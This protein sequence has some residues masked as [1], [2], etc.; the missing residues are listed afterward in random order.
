M[1]RRLNSIPCIILQIPAPCKHAHVWSCEFDMVPFGDASQNSP[2]MLAGLPNFFPS[3]S[4]FHDICFSFFFHGG[5]CFTFIIQSFWYGKTGCSRQRI[6][7]CSQKNSRET[8]HNG[9]HAFNNHI[10]QAIVPHVPPA[11]LWCDW[12]SL[13]S[14]ACIQTKTQEQKSKIC[15][16]K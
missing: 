16:E 4:S 6:S 15:R 10:R 9:S 13:I 2:L 12:L 11:T 14:R 3:L 1:K 8:R 7:R 5:C